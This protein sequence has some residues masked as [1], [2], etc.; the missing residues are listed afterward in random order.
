[1]K[2]AFIYAT[3]TLFREND[4]KE[5]NTKTRR[6]RTRKRKRILPKLHKN[7]R[8]LLRP[9]PHFHNNLVFFLFHIFSASFLTSS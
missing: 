5:L 3:A 8:S 7:M 2:T 6:E 4:V 9:S 1:M